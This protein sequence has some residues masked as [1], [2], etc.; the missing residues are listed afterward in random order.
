MSSHCHRSGNICWPKLQL[1]QQQIAASET[2][3][4]SAVR[5]MAHAEHGFGEELRSLS[6]ITHR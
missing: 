3:A 4:C 1:V 6:P 5:R 2:P